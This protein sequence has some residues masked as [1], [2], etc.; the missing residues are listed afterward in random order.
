VIVLD[1][2]THGLDPVW[3]QRFRD[4]VTRCAA[5]TA[6]SSSRRTTSTSWRGWLTA[7]AIID[8]GRLQRVVDVRGATRR[9]RRPHAVPHRAGA[10]DGARAER[11]P[12]ARALGQGRVPARRTH[13]RPGHRGALAASLASGAL[14][15]MVYPVHLD[16]RGSSSARRRHRRGRAVSR[17]R[18]G[19]YALW[20]LRRLPQGPGSL[21]GD[22]RG[23]L[24]WYL[25]MSSTTETVPIAPVERSCR[26]R[27]ALARIG[28][29]DPVYA[30][31]M[32]EFQLPT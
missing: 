2:P 3:T 11:L 30:A 8:H 10:R 19:A 24:G 1:E 28:N 13:A 6:S 31:R 29:P 14:V 32:S 4:V 20:Q 17:A 18:V 9:R 16:A 27:D 5:T 15:T 25:A 26:A 7:S 12:G 23:A 22:H 21:D